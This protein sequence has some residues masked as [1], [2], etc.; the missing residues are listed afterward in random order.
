M[1]R[2]E[3]TFKDSDTLNLS[4]DA[5]GNLTGDVNTEAVCDALVTEPNLSKLQAA[6]DTDTDTFATASGQTITFASGAALTVP[7]GS[8]LA[9]T[10]LTLSDGNS[11]DLSTLDT[12]TNTFAALAGQT[13]TFANGDTI[14]IPSGSSISGTVVATSDGNTID[15][16][17]LDTDTFATLAGQT[18]TFANGDT[19]VV[20]AGS[21]ITGT[22]IETSDGNTFDL[23]AIDTDTF[24]TL[25]GDVITFAGGA[26]YDLSAIDT[27]TFAT[28][29][30]NTITVPGGA[31]I[32]V[33]D[34][35][36]SGTDVDPWVVTDTD[37]DTATLVS[38]TDVSSV[39]LDY[40]S[41]TRTFTLGVT[42]DGVEQTDTLVLKADT[43]RGSLAAFTDSDYG[44]SHGQWSKAT[45]RPA[46]MS[47]MAEPAASTVSVNPLMLSNVLTNRANEAAD[48]AL[49]VM[50][51]DGT[52]GHFARSFGN[53]S[54]TQN[55]IDGYNGARQNIS[56]VDGATLQIP[57]GK[58][59]GQLFSLFFNPAGTTSGFLEGTVTG[60]FR[61]ILRR[62]D[63]VIGFADNVAIVRG[64]ET[65]KLEWDGVRWR[66]RAGGFSQYSQGL[67]SPTGWRE[68]LNGTATIWGNVNNLAAGATATVILPAQ[69]TNTNYRINATPKKSSA[70]AAW[71]G[72]GQGNGTVIVDS[73][74]ATRLTTSFDVKNFDTSLNVDFDYVIE[75]AVLDYAAL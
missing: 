45:N 27:D 48:G 62:T 65:W 57:D 28:I 54:A 50:N 15:I 26:T 51:A 64:N 73:N 34:I 1:A 38:D 32:S 63:H 10:I 2:T 59:P 22:V 52:L 20:P 17:S 66:V 5:D 61:G 53:A 75:N 69:T 4:V 18:I 13:I 21:T 39:R 55:I 70:S 30:G 44:L 31:S 67:A 68:N 71:S 60:N 19:L 14:N 29:T 6:L 41:A 58:Y 23:S 11:I 56:L 12:D 25:A 40:D 35:T 3:L 42:E 36:G 33:A 49:G 9:G 7:V 37:G 74:P 43:T 24:A 47:E 72:Y 16:A 8:T 46:F